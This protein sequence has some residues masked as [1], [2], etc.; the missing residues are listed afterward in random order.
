MSAFRR[1]SSTKDVLINQTL[2]EILSRIHNRGGDEFITYHDLREFWTERQLREF[3][4]IME[5]GVTRE[6]IALIRGRFLRT[7]SILVLIRWNEWR[8]FNQIFL[9]PPGNG[10]SEQGRSD[11]R[12]PYRLPELETFLARSFAHDFHGKQSIF[13]PIE[14]KEGEDMTWDRSW[15]LPFISDESKPCPPGSY[16][17]VTKEVIAVGQ[18]RHFPT[19]VAAGIVNEVRT[20][21]RT[22]CNGG[23]ERDGA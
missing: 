12:L 3:I 1:L 7:L 2:D 19:G 8:N 23:R 4:R 13:C 15:R 10:C 11:D 17:E 22:A 16:G 14:I 21:V 6:S 20:A 5:I 18:I 9:L